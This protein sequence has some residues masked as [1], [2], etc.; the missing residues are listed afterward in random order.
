M[1]SGRTPLIPFGEIDGRELGRGGFEVEEEEEE[2]EGLKALMGGTEGRGRGRSEDD[3]G[4]RGGRRMVLDDL[5]EMNEFEYLGQV[6]LAMGLGRTQ[7][8]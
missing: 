3:G 6:D 4:E 8:E 7:F 5:Q 2:L 1:L